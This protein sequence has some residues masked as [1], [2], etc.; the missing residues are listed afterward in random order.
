M[1]GAS[2]TSSVPGNGIR[3]RHA[4]RRIL[5]SFGALRGDNT[6]TAA[7]RCLRMIT[8]WTS[9]YTML[10]ELFGGRRKK[11][12]ASL[13]LL[14]VWCLRLAGVRT[15]CMGAPGGLYRP[16]PRGYNG[17][18][19]GRGAQ[20]SVTTLAGFCAD[21]WGPPTGGSRRLPTPWQQAGP[22]AKGL[23]DGWLL[24]PQPD[25]EGFVEVSVAT[26]PPSGGRSL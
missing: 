23:V 11:G 18:L 3:R 12:T 2:R 16:T 15:L 10:L 22:T 19:T 5:P 8:R 25:D 13:L 21:C 4:R 9:S 1:V 26:V 6:P 24:L 14:L 7:L 20:P 17:N